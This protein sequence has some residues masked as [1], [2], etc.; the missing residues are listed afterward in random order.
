MS[1]NNI[2]IDLKES[3]EV[4]KTFQKFYTKK[5]IPDYCAFNK[6]LTINENL[7]NIAIHML[8]NRSTSCDH[9][10][11]DPI[12]IELVA[13]LISNPSL[14]RKH[15]ELDNMK[16]VIEGSQSLS[17]I[18]KILTSTPEVKSLT[19]YFLE[20]RSFFDCLK[21][22][23]QAIPQS[24]LQS[25]LLSFYRLITADRQKF[26]RFI[27]PDTLYNILSFASDINK[28]LSILILSEYLFLS[29]DVLNQMI[30]K[31]VNKENLF[32]T[33][34]GDSNVNFQFL[35]ILEAQRLSNLSKF[36]PANVSVNTHSQS[37]IKITEADLSPG[38]SI[39][40]GI[41]VPNLVSLYNAQITTSYSSS[42]VPIAKSFN[43]MRKFATHIR[44]LDPV[45]LVGTAG[46]GKTFLVN[47][48]AKALH[49]ED[50]N[51]LIK[52]HLN[53]QTDSKTLLGTY[54]SGTKPGTFEWK[55]GVLT[56]AVKEGK[57]VLVEDIDKAPNEVLSILMGLLENRQLTIPSRGEVIRAANGFQLISTVR[58]QTN[59][60]TLPDLIGMRLWKTLILEDLESSDLK[61]ILNKKFPLLERYSDLFIKCY[62]SVKEIYDSRRF[63]SMNK[64]AQPRKIS[65]RDLIKFCTRC[66]RIFHLS[67][68]MSSDDMIHD[69]TFDSIFS[70]A[71]D[72]FTSAVVERE[73]IEVLIQ[74]IGENLEI[75]SSRIQLQLKK[76]VPVFQE[77]DD[78][79]TIGRAVVQK[80][81]IIGVN[82]K[83]R[84][85][86]AGNI[87]SFARTNHS[88]RLMEKVGMG[89]SMCEPLLLVGETGTGKTTVVQQM[90]KLLNKKL[91]VIN[92]SQQTEV[93]DL[94]GGFKPINAKTLALPL[95]EDFEELFARS[96]STKSNAPFMK[97][98]SKCFNKTQW[99]NVVKLWKEAVKMA[100]KTFEVTEDIT[101][102]NDESNRKKRKLNATEKSQLMKEWE[103]MANRVA[104]FEKQS[105]DLENSFV[106]KFVEGSLVKAIKNGDWLLLDEM[107]LATPET[108]D[109]ISDLLSEDPTQRSILLSEKGDVE[110]IKCHPSFRIFGCMNPATDVGKKDLPQSIRSRFTEIYVHSPDEDISDLLMIIDKYVGKFALSDEWVGNDIAE[111]Y[112]E[113]KK[114]SD[115]N[116]I[117]DGA[118]QKPHFS[119]R[120]L[121]RTL[122]Y[123]R[124]IVGIYGLRRSLYEGFCMSFLTLLD[125]KS[126][127]ILKPLIE[128]YTVGRMKNVKSIMNQIPRDPSDTKKQYVQFKHYWIERGP[129]EPQPQAQYIITPF[130]E[131]NMLNLVRASSGGRFPVLI[132]GP[133]SA[134]KTSMISYLAK[135]TGHKFVRINNHEHTDLQEY[136]GTY[137][138]D[139]SGKLVFKEGILVEALRKGHWIVLD[140][141]NL[142]PTDVLE[143]LN[144]LLD[145]NRELFIPETQ[146]VVTPHPDFMLFATQNPPGLYGGRK[147]LS[148][149]FKNRFLELHFDDIPQDELEIILRER[150]QIAPSYAK[151]IVE[152]YKELSV[153]R[154]ST[155][156]FEQKNS[157]ATLR[158]LFRWAL[159]EA[160]G[161][162]QL[163]ANGYMLLAERVRRPEEKIIVKQ[164]L[165]KVM[166]VTLDID[167]YYKDLE[168][169]ELLNNSGTVVWTKA[170]KRLAVLVM[171]SMKNN[172]PLLLVGETGCGKTTVCQ[173]I[174]EF[175][176]KELIIV[177]AHQNTETGDLLGAQ[178]PVRKRSELQKQL[179]TSLKNILLKINVQV[180]DGLTVKESVELWKQNKKSEGISVE[181]SRCIDLLIKDCNALFEWND[182]PLIKAL[183]TGS[184]FLL[185]EISLADDSVLER[186]NSV[187]EPERTL[188][189][190][191]KG[192]GDALVTALPGFQFLATMNPGGDYGKKELSP[193]LRN[194]FTEIWVPSMEDF[195]DVKQIVVSKL[196]SEVENLA[197]PIV[198]FSE[199]YG[200]RM[201]GGDATS[202]II[203]L[204]DIL[205]WVT[206]I[207]SASSNGVTPNNALLHGACMVFIDALG[208]HLTAHLAENEEKL[209]SMKQDFVN[210]LSE[211]AE[212]DLSIA[213]KEKYTISVLEDKF[214]CGPFS[215]P[216]VPNTETSTSFNLQAPTTAANAMRVIR[217]MQVHKPVLL[218]GSPG[219]GKTSLI[220]ALAIAT[221]NNLTR[222]NLSEQTDL[223]D[224]FGSD[225]PVE[226]GKAGEFVWKDAPFLRAMQRGEWVLLDE[227]NLASQSVLEGL[228]ACLDHRGEA[229]IPELDKSFV[230]HP[231]F[232]VFAAQNPQ[233]QGGGRKGLPKSFV[234]R[235]SVVYVDMLTAVDL[236]MIV[237]HLYPNVDHSLSEKLI[238]FMS[239]LEDEVVIKKK[240][241]SV[242][243]PWEFNLRDT[244]RWLSL[245]DS[246]TLTNEKIASD[247]FDLVVRQRFRTQKDRD[248]AVE[249]FES[250][251]GK[252]IEK[253]PVY[254]LHIDHIQCQN[255][256]VSRNP[257]I[258]Y[259][260]NHKISQLQCNVPVMETIFRCINKAYPMLLVGPSGSGKSELIKF[261]ADMIGSKVYEFSMNSDIDSMDILGGYEQADVSRA[262]AEISINILEFLLEFSAVN[263]QVHS[264]NIEII[265]FTMKLIKLLTDSALSTSNIGN[266]LAA[267]EALNNMINSS[268][269]LEFIQKLSDIKTITD[270][271]AMDVSFQWFDG[272]LVQAVEKGHWLILDNAN[273]CSPSVLDRLNSLLE[274][275]GV[276]I[277]NECTNSDGSPRIV[278]PHPNFRLF[279]T[280]DPK[281]GEISRAMR[282]RAVEVFV[283]PLNE[284]ATGIDKNILC[285][286]SASGNEIS[287]DL[288]KLKVNPNT[289]CVQ[290][291]V[292]AN[293][294]ELHAISKFMDFYDNSVNDST[295]FSSYNIVF[296]ASIKLV[297]VISQLTNCTSSFTELPNTSLLVDINRNLQFFKSNGILDKIFEIYK[298]AES[299]SPLLKSLNIL[300]CDG[301]PIAPIINTP[302]LSLIEQ[303]L[304]EVNSSESNFLIY[305]SSMVADMEY[306]FESL[307]A[308]VKTLQ[309]TSMNII[310]QSAAIYSGREIRKM[311]KLNIYKL[312]LDIFNFLKST[313]VRS[314]TV[315]FFENIGYYKALFDLQVIWQNIVTAATDFNETAIRVY[316]EQLLEWVEK[317]DVYPQPL[318]AALNADIDVFSKQLKLSRGSSMTIIWNACRSKYPQSSVAWENYEA[319]IDLSKKFDEVALKQ[320]PEN[321]S[322]V[323][324]FRKLFMSLFDE[325]LEKTQNDDFITILED[326]KMKVNDLDALSKE[327]LNPRTHPFVSLFDSLFGFIESD[328]NYKG[329]Q[330]EF[331]S[332]IL[333][334]ALFSKRSTLSL[335]NLKQ[336][337]M[338][339]PF[340]RI[341]DSLWTSDGNLKIPLFDDRF[342]KNL[343][344]S[345]HNISL[346]QGG[347]IDEAVYDMKFLIVQLLKNSPQVLADHL[348]YFADIISKWVSFVAQLH[349]DLLPTQEL[350]SECFKILETMTPESMVSLVNIH[351]ENGQGEYAAIFETY[352]MPALVSITKEADKKSVGYCFVSVAAGMIMLFMPDSTYD[353]AAVDH[354]LYDDYIKLQSMITDLRK[355]FILARG[356]YFGDS[357]IVADSCLP[358]INESELPDMPRVYRD[359]KP[360]DNLFDEWYAFFTSYIDEKHIKLLLETAKGVSE[361][362]SLQVENFN[363]SATQFVVRLKEGYN[364]YAD[365]NDILIGFIHSLKIGLILL[366]SGSVQDNSNVSS[367]WASDIAILSNTSVVNNLLE[368]VKDMC[369]KKDISNVDADIIYNFIIQI[370]AFRGDTASKFE[371]QDYFNQALL[372]LYYRWSFRALKQKEEEST[373]NG[374]FKFADPTMDAEADFQ[375]IFP[376]AEDLF[377]VS[378]MSNKLASSDLEDIYYDIAKSYLNNF[379]ASYKT[380]YEDMV[381]K[382]LIAFNSLENINNL[383]VGKNTG[384]IY[385]AAFSALK[386]SYNEFTQPLASADVDFYNGSSFYET[387]K[388][389][390]V[391]KKLQTSVHEL[392]KQWPEHATLGE[393]FRICQEFLDYPTTVPIYRMLSKVEQIFTFIAEW[394]KYAHKGV[395]LNVHYH[396]VSGLIVSWRKLE[397]ASWKQV[398]KNEEKVLEKKIGKWWFH[399]FETII[400]PTV[401][402]EIDDEFEVKVVTAINIFMSSTSYGE[403]GYR[404]GLLRAFAAHVQGLDSSSSIK[405]TLQNVI[406]FYSM[407]E[408]QIND[409]IAKIKTDLEKRVNEVILLASW[410]DIN[411]DALKQSSKKSHHAL[412]KVIRKYRDFLAQPVKSIIESGMSP[413]VKVVIQEKTT[414]LKDSTTNNMDELLK[415]C[416]EIPSWD[417]RPARLN[418]YVRV[419]A[420]MKIYISDIEKEFFPSLHEFA[421]E[422]LADAESLRKE[423]PKE[424]KKEDKKKISALKNEKHKLLSNTLRDIKDMGIKLKVTHEV[425]KVMQS[426]TGVLASSK[427][428]TGTLYEKSDA[429]FFRLLDLLPRLRLSVSELHQDIPPADA[430]KCLAATEHLMFSLV[431]N[432]TILIKSDTFSKRLN[433]AVKNLESLRY[434]GTSRAVS[435]SESHFVF[436]N[437]DQVETI[438]N[439]LPKILDYII[440]VLINASTFTNIKYDTNI[441]TESKNIL[442]N[443]SVENLSVVGT[444]ECLIVNQVIDIYQK[445]VSGL[446]D[447]KTHN[448]HVAFAADFVIEWIELQNFN[449]SLTSSVNIIEKKTV[450]N[451]END[452]RSLFNTVLLIIQKVH[453]EQLE[454]QSH[455]EDDDD[456]ENKDWLVTKQ[457]RLVRYFDLLY[458]ASVMKKLNQCI[459]TMQLI[460]FNSSDSQIASALID[461]ILPI[462]YNY[463]NLVNIIEQKLRENYIDVSR[464]TFELSTILYNLATKG[465]C[466]PELPSDEKESDQLQDGTGLGDGD[467]ATNNSKDVE[468]D[469]DLTEQAQ[470]P[471]EEEKD[472]EEEEEDDD[473][474]DIEGDMAGEL[475]NAPEEEGDDDEKDEEEEKDL[476]EEI[477]DLDD[478]D[479]NAVDEKMWD[480]EA[481]SN[482]KEKES[483][484]MP[485]DSNENDD[486]QAAE[487]NDD[488]SNKNNDKDQQ[489]GEEDKMDEDSKEEDKENDENAEEEEDVGE[490]EDDVRNDE[491][492]KFDDQADEAD[493]LEL[494]DDINLDDD[495]KSEGEGEDEEGDGNEGD[496]FDDPLDEDDE[497]ANE[498]KDVEMTKEEE[499]EEGEEGEVEGEPA[500]GDDDE[501]DEE[502][503][504][505]DDENMHED[506][507][508]A[509]EEEGADKSEDELMDVDEDEQKQQNED[510]DANGDDDVEGLEGAETGNND[511]VNEDTAVQQ[512]SGMKSEGADADTNEEDQNIGAAGGGAEFQQDENSKEEGAEDTEE[513]PES[514]REK[515]SEAMKQLGDSL[516]EFHRRRQEIKE[517]TDDD[518]V[519]QK[520]GERPDDFQ[521]LEGEN[522]E[523]ETQALGAANKDQIQSIDDEMAIEDDQ[524]DDQDEIKNENID[525]NDLNEDDDNLEAMDV[526]NEAEDFGG[527]KRSATMGERQRELDDDFDMKM[528]LDADENS[529]AS[530]I[531]DDMM[532]DED[533]LQT[534]QLRT[535]EEAEFLWKDADD[536]T[537]ELTSSLCEQLRLILEPT[538]STKLKGDYKTGKRLNMK[539]IIPYIASQ[540]RKDKIWMRRTK[541]SKRQYQIMISVDDSKS[542]A[543]SKSVDIAFQSIALVSKALTQLESGQLSVMK[544]GTDAEVVHPFEK[545]FAGDSGINVFR[546]FDFQ[547]TRTDVRKLVSKSL[548]VFNDAR[549][550]GDSDLWQLQIVLSDGVCEDH[551]T[552][553]RLVR[554]AREEKVMIVFVIIDGLNNQESIMDMSQVNYTTDINGKMKLEV[555][556]YLD[557][558]PFEFYVVVHNVNE[559][560]EMLSLIL[561]QYFTELAQ[562]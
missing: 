388:A 73:P 97:L 2:I 193:A 59:E 134:G 498:N 196:R 463:M 248:S 291:F 368:T 10:A 128:K 107:N 319:L 386:Q 428:L 527:E 195:Q 218:E 546:N 473:A 250:I 358:T 537:R 105:V 33:L 166:R 487:D 396:S 141:L 395:S 455:N 224:L 45:M 246:P 226:G 552:I 199:W 174:A 13:R 67:G 423:T 523:N 148:K 443:L 144:R 407:F 507:T 121:T 317:A 275:D 286:T 329:L 179:N 253:D 239:H 171:T 531:D 512:T 40:A 404:L 382:S 22:C 85:V 364:R 297:G 279:L 84:A 379:D 345:Q 483:D 547:D 79:I 472:R 381:Q 334:L 470:Q 145:D 157:F 371:G 15:L 339:K 270:K 160:V 129:D 87:T 70:E 515:A 434:S 495:G 365:L 243:E 93:G 259:H 55:N 457:K 362:A 223:I 241:G 153:Q 454:F 150:C 327:F 516:K 367:L 387:K 21:N 380:D 207:N 86:A 521:H 535:Y 12:V 101:E 252:I 311:P 173:M 232:K 120:T 98:L 78:S 491:D 143:A 227:M 361:K 233:Y 299:K 94:L 42:F 419:D 344:K 549:S 536:A 266:I 460:D 438:L 54:T 38:V 156:V 353:P 268:K 401:A 474:V 202:G 357:K 53:Q 439:W 162:E 182:G 197:D 39:I 346:T 47:E 271:G 124:E 231:N 17:C 324:D 110:S 48:L 151:K 225:V 293:N 219:V 92:V 117:V 36:Q 165:E 486:M 355:T 203:S 366:H 558:F 447:W 501:N 155:R 29:E 375:R 374:V 176:Q 30:E 57:W 290:S 436:S 497:T 25:L 90:A 65:M 172:E 482:T 1:E 8:D 451:L 169:P 236:N 277:I 272:L 280:S 49:I 492:E 453:K 75:P 372:A 450:V 385:S 429:Y 302:F 289:K 524:Q 44:T 478:M 102:D 26:Q 82:R 9:F 294:S 200:K 27:D 309:V 416:S 360:L 6:K 214:L 62:F 168:V 123:V 206:F 52:I 242:G 351:K 201:G 481:E 186:L 23:L 111:L 260:S 133:T 517:S 118:N 342:L 180:E 383:G 328:A 548:N 51:N 198:A 550:F 310:E 273:L 178:R 421:K 63:V 56:T 83:N 391:I 276:L 560:P 187:L 562:S 308:K 127:D 542:M 417:E 541:P 295:R 258:Q 74:Q 28:Y 287:S 378:S 393:L 158:D 188:L 359:K 556:K 475:E 135:I 240:W 108:L 37:I 125:G 465:F 479:P 458:P 424:Y 230:S 313:L 326:I 257:L 448:P 24:E 11:F 247:F 322:N 489:N 559:L 514:S 217:A 284:R 410:K 81:Q 557:S 320:F 43:A 529:E 459:S 61:V 106:F 76:N 300:N 234:N 333:S 540:F 126:E 261:A 213:F 314:L 185:D 471:N 525:E 251:F 476:D 331:D 211:F 64:G 554:K 528:E 80:Q 119:I 71:I 522:A 265:S 181:D 220:N 238:Q 7:N 159:R 442:Q 315:K 406:Q 235:F 262:L 511:E 3:F 499:E 390:S 115:S 19:E 216:R 532:I 249:I 494:P 209:R 413:A 456:D 194:R 18:S 175:F 415:L 306:Y 307:H 425:Q 336:T 543:E 452:F 303:E 343:M 399:L 163:A 403:Y 167:Q 519:D 321:T 205:A 283:L 418:N 312:I 177:N 493:A 518:M 392:L 350:K 356:I 189:L 60:S 384:S 254:A 376:D 508:E 468:E 104:D 373:E 338:F 68:V 267:I 139:D 263:L 389:G 538:L 400:L 4:Y 184:Y 441:F 305:V 426:V 103:I 132:Q 212:S 130:V 432:R 35:Q 397:L 469:D 506:G 409:S 561:R 414:E 446:N 95:Q 496:E 444:N 513:Q 142:A 467:G 208:T 412:Y 77:H 50:S 533:A 461:H 288:E 147:V 352:F 462:V 116:K 152:V 191:E 440:S 164:V 484:K 545:Q 190:A 500:S 488:E 316:H 335:R 466:Q 420:N 555:N 449:F 222:I 298:V 296:F 99:K 96:F 245:I 347:K 149:A 354:V 408:P 435:T 122:L 274:R 91:T 480:E 509:N 183:K 551:E 369:K 41:L 430:Q 520:T 490:Q 137:V 221:G 264:T 285:L 140:E 282:N 113:A 31:H 269:L 539:R 161:Y 69:D 136:L 411:I 394:E 138:S 278:K 210:K 304:T 330:Q 502:G 340:P 256:I 363:K 325:C 292:Q 530:D 504:N 255:E 5:Q 89:I 46:S 464:G 477:D 348:S 88:A 58:T 332:D 72:C 323:N 503:E 431:A 437:R 100:N 422:I 229:Y 349:I 34:D 445:L 228:N 318:V 14:A 526:D 301:Q 237:R 427:S 131:K 192:S 534:K 154:Q 32:G 402:G 510:D 146:E 215:I 553:Q 544:F 405:D 204:R 170:M 112:L 66:D 109:S 485:E 244:L 281:F 16:Y 398:F 505:D 377:D 114:L 433:F 337:E 20:S 341:L 370:S